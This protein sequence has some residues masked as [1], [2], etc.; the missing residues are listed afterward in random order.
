MCTAEIVEANAQDLAAARTSELEGPLP[1]RL[2][3][4]ERGMAQ[5]IEGVLQVDACADP[6]GAITDLACRP[7]GIQ[8]GRMR[9]PLGVVGII[10]ESP[11][12]VTVDA[13]VLSLT[14]GNACVPRGGSEAIRSNREIARWIAEGL[15]AAGLPAAAVQLVDTTDRAALGALPKLSAHVD[16]L[17]PRGDKRL[18]ERVTAEATIPGIRHVDGGCHV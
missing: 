4:D 6:I 2:G 15:A 10:H 8:V 9:V 3:L 7:T 13:A 14:S 12:N 5:M 11:Q 17:V 16:V 1:E 18:I